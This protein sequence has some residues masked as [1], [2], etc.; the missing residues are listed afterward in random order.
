M[1]GEVL[2]IVDG[3]VQ[4]SIKFDTVSAK[5]AA[6]SQFSQVRSQ[7]LHEH[8]YADVQISVVEKVR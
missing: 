1:S 2:L 4:D 8:P 7:I 3:G 5:D 6:V